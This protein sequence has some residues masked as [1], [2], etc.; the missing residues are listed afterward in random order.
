MTFVGCCVALHSA[1]AGFALILLCIP[2]FDIFQY[3][4]YHA[5]KVFSAFASR[6]GVVR[7]TPRLHSNVEDELSLPLMLGRGIPLLLPLVGSCALPSVCRQ[8]KTQRSP[9]LP[10]DPFL[11]RPRIRS[12]CATDRLRRTLEGA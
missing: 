11:D 4:S 3:W 5:T 10:T 12:N 7:G 2:S 9:C 6:G 1:R 8:E